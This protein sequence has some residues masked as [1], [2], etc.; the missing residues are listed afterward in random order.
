MFRPARNKI[1]IDDDLSIDKAISKAKESSGSVK[2]SKQDLKEILQDPPKEPVFPVNML[3]FAAIKDVID[4]ADISGVAIIVTTIFSLFFNTILF[5]WV[6]GR[7]GSGAMSR[8]LMRV[9]IKFLVGVIIV[10]FIPVVKIIPATTLFVLWV[11]TKETELVKFIDSILKNLKNN[12]SWNRFEK[13][14]MD[15]FS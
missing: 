1:D 10:E 2:V 11:H 3:T 4:S 13:E 14:M 15:N 9:L 12:K 8:T 7:G 5:F 6:T